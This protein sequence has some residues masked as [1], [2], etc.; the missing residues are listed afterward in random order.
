MAGLQ[1]RDDRR[2]ARRAIR[3]RNAATLRALLDG[4][5]GPIRD[6]VLLNAAAALIVSGKAKDLKAG[7]AIGVQSIA[8]GAARRSLDRLVTIT[9][10]PDA[11]PA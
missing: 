11:T 10:M 5:E 9:N 6:I 8:S 3:K 2:S 4:K 7:V 1:T